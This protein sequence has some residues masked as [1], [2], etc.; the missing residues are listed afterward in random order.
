MTD[1]PNLWVVREPEPLG[2]FLRPYTRDFRHLANLVASGQS[3]GAGVVI[4]GRALPESV[5]LRE[6]VAAS[7]KDVVLDSLG[8]EIFSPT[9]LTYTAVK[10]LPWLPRKR[11]ANSALSAEER[12]IL[13][14][15]L[16]RVAVE[17]G[18]RSV[19]A[20]AKFIQH[21]H[22]DDV[23]HDVEIAI[24]LRAA[25]D[26]A[27]GNEVRIYY[28]LIAGL[29]LLGSATARQGIFTTLRAGVDANAI[30]AIWV[31]AV[32]FD[33]HS[34]S[35]NLKRYVA[36]SRGLHGLG[37]PL[38][39]DR[40][41]TL[42]LA[43]LA[44]GVTSAISSGITLGERYDPH[45]L[46]KPKKGTGFIPPP[47]VYI[48]AIGAFMDR[49]RAGV[50][51]KH[52]SVRNWFG[53]QRSCCSA[54]GVEDTL[55]DPRRH[56]VVTRTEEVDALARVPTQLRASQYME[57]WLRPASDRATKAMRID[58]LLE[59]HRKR[60]DDWRSTFAA[61]IEEDAAIRPQVTR[62]AIRLPERKGA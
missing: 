60:L 14:E 25:L 12:R 40:A 23:A 26:A 42:G 6:T 22:R 27:G 24:E 59:A 62:S 21:I 32:G 29:R 37:V 13:C 55:G 39:G 46:F 53:C 8:V 45:P 49:A 11:Y 36:A 10:A 15:E 34:G 28:P 48:P 1:V 9:G 43:M 54:R 31:R 17:L 61:I 44:L 16:A 47:R 58:P 19:L 30:D 50:I 57:R 2:S 4:D 18:F 56:F 5:E 20:P 33:I 35:I 51:L 7:A 52:P 3:A 38:V 41:G